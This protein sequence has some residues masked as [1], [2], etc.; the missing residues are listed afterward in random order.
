MATN[1][2]P[3]F[4]IQKVIEALEH[5]WD[6]MWEQERRNPPDRK[7]EEELHPSSFPY[8]GYRHAMGWLNVGADP[9]EFVMGAHMMYYV[10]LGTSA[11]LVFQELIGK[12]T[13]DE[14][15]VQGE[16]VG[17]WQCTN[18]KCGHLVEFST[19]VRCPKCDSD[20]RYEELGVTYGKRT[21]G[22]LD[23]LFRIKYRGKYLY[24][25]IDYK[26]LQRQGG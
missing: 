18:P 1:K 9:D 4:K 14:H 23:G 5:S 10:T 25:V 8:C 2:T 11:H 12:L 7:R 15:E 13:I 21:H 19:Y 20:T 22:H 24:F 17:D 16:M 6:T 3:T 26:N